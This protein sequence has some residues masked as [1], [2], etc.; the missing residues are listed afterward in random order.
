MVN[1]VENVVGFSLD[2]GEE[3]IGKSLRMVRDRMDLGVKLE[4]ELSGGD[5][6]C[7]TSQD[8]EDLAHVD[9]P[10]LK[11]VGRNNSDF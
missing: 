11:G 2:R 9:G 8:Y 1:Y 10:V 5:F 7:V 4:R 3:D 6:V